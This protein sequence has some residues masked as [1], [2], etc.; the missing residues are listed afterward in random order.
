M[1]RVRRRAG[2]SQAEFARRI[3]LSVATMRGWE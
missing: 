1:R 3:G 2:L